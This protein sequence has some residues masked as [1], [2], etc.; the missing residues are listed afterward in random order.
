M[1]KKKNTAVV[2]L[3]WNGEKLF[4]TFLPSVLKHS[5]N[6]EIIVA[7]N[8]STDGSLALLREKFPEVTIIELLENYGFAEGYNRA[9][10]QVDAEYLILLNS[11]VKVAENWIDHCIARF[12]AD[13]NI[14][15]IQPKILS[16]NQPEYFEYAGAAGGFID[17]F[18]YP[19]CRG[20]IL[21]HIEKDEGQY[22]V[23]SPIFWA[24]GAC[25]FVRA[26]AFKAAG[27]FDSDFWAHME[28]IDLCWRL[29]G[30]GYKIVYEPQSVV[31]H[32]GGGTLSYGS[33]QKIYLNFRNNLWMLFK[34]LP[35]HQFKRI[36]FIR[37]VLD[38]VAAVK[39]LAGFNF[40]AFRAVFKAHISFYQN[41]S[42]LIKKRKLVQQNVK[43]KNHQEIYKKS[44]M[45]KFFIQNRKK[46]SS[47]HLNL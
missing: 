29:K 28:E 5:K 37:M 6:V 2:I 12:D 45:W 19:F 8:A 11:D 1:G 26:A 43:V 41:I 18:G 39:F 20:R 10:E 13:E 32:L 34:N 30:I 25:M 23:A 9:L 40:M 14:A 47:Y 46:F 4:E 35:K 31:Y 42:K 24:S 16:Y 33:P 44:I 21:N 3:N 15:A 38:G 17:K 7:D 27:G 36:F 22:D